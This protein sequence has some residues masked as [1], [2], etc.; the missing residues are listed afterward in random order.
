MLMDSR[1]LRVLAAKINRERGPTRT[2]RVP[3]E[4]DR[5]MPELLADRTVPVST[6]A[7]M[8]REGVAAIAELDPK[9]LRR[10][11]SHMEE[12]DRVYSFLQLRT[13]LERASRIHSSNGWFL[14]Y[15]FGYTS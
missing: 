9:R 14:V 15:P 4:R 12:R 10:T 11:L 1:E 6:A 7:L 8:H 13:T 3:N 2:E 5:L